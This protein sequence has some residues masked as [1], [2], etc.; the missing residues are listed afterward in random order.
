MMRGQIQ[1][2]Q[3]VGENIVCAIAGLLIQF[4]RQLIGKDSLIF[5]SQT[6][7]QSESQLAPTNGLCKEIH[8]PFL[9]VMPLA[10]IE[11]RQTPRESIGKAYLLAKHRQLFG[12]HLDRNLNARFPTSFFHV[13]HTGQHVGLSLNRLRPEEE[14]DSIR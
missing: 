9:I 3:D 8:Y 4:D 10:G 14:R 11:R 13:E 12:A 1:L 2:S 7:L 5:L 6:S